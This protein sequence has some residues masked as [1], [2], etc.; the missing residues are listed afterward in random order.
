MLLFN[1]T[2]V[3]AD[4][5]GDIPTPFPTLIPTFPDPGEF[6]IRLLLPDGGQAADY[7]SEWLKKR[8]S[9]DEDKSKDMSSDGNTVTF[10]VNCNR[11]AEKSCD[12]TY[13][14][15]FY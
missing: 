11:K 13:C 12:S 4:I 8:W 3:Y 6:F 2:V 9:T 1:T 14:T 7:I 10:N 15:K 5:G